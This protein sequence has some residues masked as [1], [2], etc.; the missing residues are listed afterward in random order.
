MLS[1]LCVLYYN[2][3]SYSK[4]SHNDKKYFITI[5]PC[6][7]NKTVEEISRVCIFNTVNN[8]SLNFVICILI[9]FDKLINDKIMSESHQSNYH[10][11]K[12]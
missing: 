12:I 9:K 3:L 8:N 4:S 6:V 11:V 7:T 10:S 2:V 5:F 1:M